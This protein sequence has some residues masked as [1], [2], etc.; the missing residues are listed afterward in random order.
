MLGEWSH[1]T[2]KVL[3]AQPARLGVWTLTS[4]SLVLLLGGVLLYVQGSDARLAGLSSDSPV[5][6]LAIAAAALLVTGFG[7]I[8]TL[9]RP[10]SAA[11]WIFLATGAA[12]SLGGFLE[13]YVIHGIVLEPGSLPAVRFAAW[14]LTWQA[15][16]TLWLPL[17][18]LLLVFPDG[19]ALGPR[20][21]LVGWLS[22]GAVTLVA[23]ATALGPDPL[24]GGVRPPLSLPRLADLL[25]PLIG[26]GWVLTIV[27]LLLSACSVVVRFRRGTSDERQQLKWV[28][29]S[30]SV[31]VLG[32]AGLV[33]TQLFPEGLRPQGVITLFGWVT[34]IGFASLPVT[35]TVAIL[36]Y[37]LYDIDLVI[38][39]TIVFAAVT[40]LLFAVYV[41]IVVSLGSIFEQRTS[42]TTSLLATVVVAVAFQPVRELVQRAIDRA[43]FGYRSNPYEAIS[44]LGD[45]LETSASARAVLVNV[46]ETIA[47]A[48]KLP[49]V[50]LELTEGGR[51]AGI[52][53]YGV[54]G[55]NLHDFPLVYQGQI[56]GTLRASG[57]SARER[58][59][60]ADEQLMGDFA[61]HVAILAHVVGLSEELQASRERIVTTREEER[62]RLRR[63]LHDGLG[64]A[65]AGITLQAEAA[66][67]LVASDPDSARRQLTELKARLKEITVDVR[68]L[69]YDLRP[70]TLD[71]LGLA[72]AIKEQARRL[73][74]GDRLEVTARVPENLGLLPAAV[75]AAAYRIVSE[76][77]T[78]ISSHAHAR[79]C[80]ISIDANHSL[81]IEIRDDGVGMPEDL[82]PGVGL[83][84]M[85]E[86]ADELGG[87]FELY[88][89]PQSGTVVRASIPLPDA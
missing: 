45:T 26:L 4:L 63:D 46:V 38:N 41:G 55:G 35:A 27:G 36:K 32:A 18:L 58:L 47:Q 15:G 67:D 11:S 28:A 81:D 51:P 52:T 20:W 24:P 17:I 1:M 86:R 60:T 37:R 40:T 78:N 39:R 66:A 33:G 89:D 19:R 6:A 21:K 72:D 10:D 82:R 56:L 48:L 71:E 54:S 14:I 25:R 83:M 57:R 43:M 53:T 85:R 61:R 16:F 68:R 88:S 87:G 9:K 64:S 34:G 8:L 7:T 31:V 2:G 80:E 29:Y 74:D 5:A 70:P 13:R 44:R 49:Y 23:S 84:S 76:A 62:R 79:H 42:F 3:S 69:V 22:V 59:S 77:L 50:A 75:E 65:L 12:F 73:S 30:A